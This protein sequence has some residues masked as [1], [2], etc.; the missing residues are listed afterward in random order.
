MF[1]PAEALGEF[2]DGFTSLRRTLALTPEPE[3]WNVFCLLAR[4]ASG[5]VA[6]GCD[7]VAAMDTMLD[8]ALAHGL[9]EL[10][11]SEEVEATLTEIFERRDAE[12]EYP[13]GNGKTEWVWPDVSPV[14]PAIPIINPFPI[15]LSELPRR[16]W[17]IPGLLLRRQVTLL[18]APPGSG[19]SLLT[20]QLA[21]VVCAG[22]PE[23]GGWRPRGKYRVLVINVE[24]DQDEMRRRLGAAAKVMSIEQDDLGWLYLAKT[25]S[26]VVARADSRTKTVVATPMLGEIERVIAENQIDIVIVD[27][28]AETFA[29]DENS[30]SELKWAAILWR[31]VARRCDCSVMLIHHAKKYSSG[32][33]GDPDAG[34]GA[35]ALTGVARIV[36][37]LFNMT[38]GEASGFA[39]QKMAD[40]TPF[41]PEQRNRYIRFD[42]A[43]ANQSL[44]S[45]KAKWFYKTSISLDNAGDGEPADEVGVLIP[46]Q[47]PSIFG[48]MDIAQAN[49]ILDMIARGFIKDDGSPSGDPFTMAKQSGN[50]WVGTPIASVLQCDDKDAAVVLKKW[51]GEGVIDV[52]KAVTSISK[53]KERDCAFV[54]NS[55]RPGMVT[56]E[57]ML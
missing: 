17:M 28:F 8:I 57:V 53:G 48:R 15:V 20:L 25:D 37:T 30:N 9:I 3:R 5:Y 41:D 42:D 2:T 54:N 1:D 44:V 47:P 22:V 51:I 16:P 27:P 40:G 21:I 46:W 36:A 49:S 43:K 31:D 7:K 32:M 45:I 18:V 34:R 33:A 38:E 23:W 19:K 39:D 29:G 14:G 4:E 13:N 24:E 11:G 35:G 52:R 6:I 50:R 55:K 56:D 26:I 10:Q 12:P